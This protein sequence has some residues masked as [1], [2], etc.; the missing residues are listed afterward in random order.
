M[1]NTG[2]LPVDYQA[3]EGNYFKLQLGENTFRVLSS[4]IVGWEYWNTDN[5]PVRSK[6]AFMNTPAD[7]RQE[8]GKP[9]AVKFFWAFVVYSH[10]AGKA[11][12]MEITQSS[13]QQA[14]SGLVKNAKWGDPKEYDITITRTGSGLDTEY[15]VVPN[16]KESMPIDLLIPNVKLEALYSGDDPFAV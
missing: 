15:Q 3:P 7:I 16:P 14:I 5:K 1:E 11:Q 4:A 9:T 12:I 13:I 6:T 10:R 2:F 8:N